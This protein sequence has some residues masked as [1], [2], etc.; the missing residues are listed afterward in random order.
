MG[1][2]IMNNAEKNGWKILGKIGTDK[3]LNKFLNEGSKL[4][5][6]FIKAVAQAF[7][8]KIVFNDDQGKMKWKAKCERQK[9]EVAKSEEQKCEVAK[10]EGPKSKEQ[11]CEEPKSEVPKSEG[12]KLMQRV[13]VTQKDNKLIF[14]DSESI[15]LLWADSLDQY[16]NQI[17]SDVDKLG[18][19]DDA[20][21]K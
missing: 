20:G 9:C 5:E 4:T 6:G 17:K 16:A 3:G 2:S 18:K 7:R 1:K 13:I 12:Q 19:K 10:S 11:K 21:S 8:T 14:E 15:T